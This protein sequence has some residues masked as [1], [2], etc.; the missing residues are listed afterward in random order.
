MQT[1]EERQRKRREKMYNAGWKLMQ[2]W[3]KRK[4]SRPLK[5]NMTEFTKRLKKITE[6]MDKDG[7]S[8]LFNLLIKIAKSKK[9]EE[10]L[11]RKT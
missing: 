11:I 9:E 4:E 6:D 10:K 1:D 7:L 5:L 8:T 2:I 3:V